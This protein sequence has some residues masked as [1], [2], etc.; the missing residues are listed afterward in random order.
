VNTLWQGIFS[1]C[2][3]PREQQLLFELAI[4]LWRLFASL[5]A[6]FVTLPEV[7]CN[8]ILYNKI[9]NN[10]NKIN[11]KR[12][13]QSC[14]FQVKFLLPTETVVAHLVFLHFICLDQSD[15]SISDSSANQIS[16]SQK[17]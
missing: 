4:K 12:Y 13:I 6:K 16:I 8:Y 15:F 5:L 14:Q 3:I 10:D 1:E 17:S 7:T 9:I 2:F 11:G